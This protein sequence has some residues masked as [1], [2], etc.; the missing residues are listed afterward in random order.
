MSQQIL[1]LL[2]TN[3]YVALKSFMLFGNWARSKRLS[4]KSDQKVFCYLYSK[5]S[6]YHSQN[7]DVQSWD[8]LTKFLS[9]ISVKAPFIS[10]K[11]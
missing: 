1:K 8:D 6:A 7:E 4:L 5:E 3:P 10:P 2:E 9:Y 11:L